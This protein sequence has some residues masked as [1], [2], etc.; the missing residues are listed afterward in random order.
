M[1]KYT[2][3]KKCVFEYSVEIYATSEDAA[4]EEAEMRDDEVEW[5]PGNRYQIFSTESEVR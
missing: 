4:V 2:V 1:Q 5:T 3:I